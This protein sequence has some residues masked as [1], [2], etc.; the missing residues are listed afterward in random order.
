MSEQSLTPRS[1]GEIFNRQ[2]IYIRWHLV[3][4]KTTMYRSILHH[5]EYYNYNVYLSKL[6]AREG[7]EPSSSVLQT[8]M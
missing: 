7:I 3:S 6:E 1:L 5:L 4:C 2:D 8:D